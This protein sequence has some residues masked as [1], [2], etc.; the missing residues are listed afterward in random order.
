MAAPP[1]VARVKVL[2]K[3]PD[4]VSNYTDVLLAYVEWFTPFSHSS[5]D[6]STQLH[7]I[8]HSMVEKKTQREA[9]I[10]PADSIIRS[11]HLF[12]DFGS[13]QNAWWR[14]ATVLDTCKTFFFNEHMD[15]YTFMSL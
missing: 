12:P 6:R 2:F 13:K 5:K 4:T 9:S 15:L 8:K 3:V 7:R 1:R 10:I 14:S 11:C